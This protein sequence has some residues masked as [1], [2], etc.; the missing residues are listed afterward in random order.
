MKINY[1]RASKRV[2]ESG[3]VRTLT[4]L[5]L[6]RFTNV[7]TFA[8]RTSANSCCCCYPRGCAPSTPLENAAFLHPISVSSRGQ[9]HDVPVCD[10][11]RLALAKTANI[12]P[13]RLSRINTRRPRHSETLSLPPPSLRIPPASPPPPPPPSPP[14]PPTTPSPVHSCFQQP[15]PRSSGPIQLP[16]LVVTPVVV[17]SATFSP[18]LERTEHPLCIAPLVSRI[19]PPSLPPSLHSSTLHLS[20]RG[21]STTEGSRSVDTSVHSTSA[22]STRNRWSSTAGGR[23]SILVESSR[24]PDDRGFFSLLGICRFH[25]RWEATTYAIV[26]ARRKEVTGRQDVDGR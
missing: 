21:G 23:S 26:R 16:P 14:L 17:F 25:F 20:I 3:A 2:V 1:A 19:V 24:E 18:T 11:Y 10:V 6:L 4:A 8:F 9:V 22:R 12:E 13:A 15:P 5:H 7:P